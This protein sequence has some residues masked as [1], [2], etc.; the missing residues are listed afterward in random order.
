[1]RDPLRTL[2]YLASVATG[3][4]RPLPL[5]NTAEYDPNAKGDGA[6]VTILVSKTHFA[7][8][9]RPH[10]REVTISRVNADSS[11]WLRV[12]RRLLLPTLGRLAGTDLYA[13]VRK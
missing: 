7:R 12:P 4:P 13:Q 9:L 6:P 2:R 10:F 11:K 1:M 8:L 5:L 3:A